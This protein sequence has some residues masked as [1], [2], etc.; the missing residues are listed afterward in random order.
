[1][2][3]LETSTAW[4]RLVTMPRPSRLVV[5]AD[6]PEGDRSFSVGELMVDVSRHLLDDDILGAL[7]AVAAERGVDEAWARMCSGAHINTSEDRAVGHLALRCGESEAF[8][9]DGRDVVPD[10]HDTLRRM[11]AFADALRAGRMFGAT[12]KPIRAVVNIGIGGSDLGP[13]LLTEALRPYAGSSVDCRFVSNVDPSD[14][15]DQLAGLDPAETVVV[16]V[17]KTFTTAETLANAAAARDWLARGV[18]DAGAGE[19]LVAVSADPSAVSNFGI[20]GSRTFPMWEWVGG[21]FSIGSA[22]S[23]AAMVAIGPAVFAEFLAG[24]RDIDHHVS[25]AS[26]GANVPLLLAL[27]GVW[28]RCV[29]GF[30]T[31]AVLPYS[32]DL[33]SLPAYLQQLIMESNGK[34]VRLDGTVPP[35]PTS[36]V[37]WGGVGTDAQHAFMQFLHQSADI[38]PVDFIGFARSHDGDANRQSTLFLNMV[39]Q[40]EALARGRRD[41][42][43]PHRSFP[44]GRPSTVLVAPSLTPR[45]LGNIVALYEHAVFFEGI[46]LGINSFDQWGVELGKEMAQSLGAGDISVGARSLPGAAGLLSWFGDHAE[47]PGAGR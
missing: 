33:R 17:S 23:L 1:M 12:G 36:P 21:R 18:G 45:A 40:A 19:H 13:V 22:V 8:T 32:Y 44:G 4:R 47:S 10:V 30:P 20:A 34:A 25:V 9:I 27:I 35:C 29:L 31:R 28:N 15:A 42:A 37:I 39:A 46:V 3:G 11:G 6:G 26:P 5:R 24:Q 43:R 2:D 7:Y 16:V 41:D 38:V 14:L